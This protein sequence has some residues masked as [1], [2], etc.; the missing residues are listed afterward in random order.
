MV[1]VGGLVSQDDTGCSADTGMVRSE[2]GGSEGICCL[3]TE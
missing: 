2:H 1:V 3:G